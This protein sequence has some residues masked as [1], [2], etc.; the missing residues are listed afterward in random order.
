MELALMRPHISPFKQMPSGSSAVLYLGSCSHSDLWLQFVVEIYVT[1]V[2][3]LLPQ[4]YP[5]RISL[6]KPSPRRET[7]MLASVSAETGLGGKVLLAGRHITAIYCED[8]P[9]EP[10]VHSV[11]KET[12]LHRPGWVLVSCCIN[13]RLATLALGM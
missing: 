7:T 3:E 8:G 11:H 1:G 2:G 13:F 5:K 9:Q 10:F 4:T 12:Q 6:K